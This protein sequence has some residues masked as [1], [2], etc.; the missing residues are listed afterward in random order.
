MPLT[1]IA[2]LTWPGRIIG[3]DNALPWALPADLKRFKALTMGHAVLMGRKTWESLPAKFR[4]LPGRL[5]LVLTR[6]PDWRGVG[7]MQVHSLDQA[8][9]RARMWFDQ[10]ED[11]GETLPKDPSLFVIGGAEVFALALPK[12]KRLALTLIEH[13]FPGDVK[14]P[15]LDLAQWK[16]AARE[17]HHQKGE[18]SFD[19]AFVDYTRK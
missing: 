1:L 9:E 19:F 7:A 17:P 13:P 11:Q 4:P 14:F 3:K 15:A 18:V 6:K 10:R 16:E 2:A 12:A 8:E 5:N